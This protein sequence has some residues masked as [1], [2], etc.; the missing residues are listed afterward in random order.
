MDE[1]VWEESFSVGVKD[2]DEQ[3]KQ[4]IKMVNTLI[5]K[6]DVKVDS[7]TI[8]DVLTELTKY[9]EYHFE[10]E[11]QYL[12]D[13]DYPEYSAHK[14]QHKVFKKKV[15]TFCIE[16]MAEKVTI[17]AEILSYLKSWLVNHILESDMKYK[18]FFKN[19][20]LS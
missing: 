12:I 17:P 16:T 10:K 19:H 11:E 3:H 6:E 1:I 4:L 7:E 2:L 18:T 9:A 5:N 14:E 20:R 13:Y 15:V 8:S